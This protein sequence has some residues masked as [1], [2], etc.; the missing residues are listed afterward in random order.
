MAT[1]A[2]LIKTE[3]MD[4]DGTTIEKGTKVRVLNAEGNMLTGWFKFFAFVEN[5]NTGATW[6]DVC[7][8]IEA[9]YGQGREWRAF[10][11][12]RIRLK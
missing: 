3:Q 7:G 11:K 1:A 10:D 6:V 8:P 12:G 2:H 9:K 4:V 5:A